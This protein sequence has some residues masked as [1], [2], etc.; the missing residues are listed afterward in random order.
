MNDDHLEQSEVYEALNAYVDR[1]L[2]EQHAKL[3]A[4]LSRDELVLY[5]LA[6]EMKGIQPGADVPSEAFLT[7]L[8]TAVDRE[9]EQ[10]RA[11]IVPRVSQRMSRASVLRTAGTLAAGVLVGVALDH[12]INSSHPTLPPLVEASGRWY[13]LAS[14]ADVPTG[15]VHR[16]SAG[17]VDGY[18]FNEGGSYRAVS[19]I[20]T[21][22]GC[23]LDWK[24]EMG[25]FH[26]LC[27]EAQ[28]EANGA[29]AAGV[30]TIPLPTITVREEAGQIY[31]WGT[32]QQ[33]WG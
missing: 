26:C 24:Q 8:K 16:F 32:Q 6:A 25:R 20:C 30:P 5:V 11:R 4:G 10:R 18:L 29:V 12:Q 22:M 2:A 33:A 1:L 15:S 21:H 3:P 27:H 19:A 9:L 14:S 7:H 28:Y 13:L 23:H 31:A 17:G